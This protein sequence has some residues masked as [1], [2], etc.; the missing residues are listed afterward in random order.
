MFRRADHV[1]EEVGATVEVPFLKM[2]HG[3]ITFFQAWRF[4]VRLVGETLRQTNRND[5][6]N[7][8]SNK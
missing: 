8:E 7:R 3:I 6:A 4:I 2:K 1:V 5:E